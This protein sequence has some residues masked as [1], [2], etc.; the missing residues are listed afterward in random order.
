MA[1]ITPSSEQPPARSARPPGSGGV[2]QGVDSQSRLRRLSPLPYTTL[3]R[4]FRHISYGRSSHVPQ[5]HNSCRRGSARLTSNCVGQ[6]KETST[7]EEFRQ[8]GDLTVGR[9]VGDIKFIADWPG[10]DLGKGKRV[11]GYID[12]QWVVDKKGI[13]STG[14]AGNASNTGCSLWDA[15][16]KQI[17][18]ARRQHQRCVREGVIWKKSDRVFGWRITGGGV[19]DGR[20]HA[21][22]GEMGFPKTARL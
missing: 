14:V 13:S 4:G 7:P 20:A 16:S 5:H 1:I 15:V 19:A 8:L 6:T 11:V 3:R 21:G 9:W 22:T 18:F 12:Y 17:K 2:G 10:Q